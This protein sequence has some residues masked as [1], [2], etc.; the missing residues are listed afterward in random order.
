VF[1]A[2]SRSAHSWFSNFDSRSSF[3]QLYGQGAPKDSFS[4][5]S[6]HT[7]IKIFPELLFGLEYRAWMF[8]HPWSLDSCILFWVLVQVTVPS[9]DLRQQ[10]AVPAQQS[11]V[12]AQGFCFSLHFTARFI[13]GFVGLRRLC[14][15]SSIYSFA[16]GFGTRFI[17]SLGLSCCRPA[18]SPLPYFSAHE[19]GLRQV[20]FGSHC[21][22]LR[23]CHRSLANRW[24]PASSLSRQIWG[25]SFP[26]SLLDFHGGFSIS[27]TRCSMKCL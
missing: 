26:S 23:F 2:M 3:F 11:G 7:T 1:L 22:G 13:F 14:R 27:P 5:S 6:R 12:A 9:L 25:L 18:C 17:H 4:A 20:D 16:S 19:Q 15:W 10:H 21:L 8:S 24:K